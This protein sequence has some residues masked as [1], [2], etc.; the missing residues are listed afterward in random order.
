[1]VIIKP[2]RDSKKKST[3]PH[4]YRPIMRNIAPTRMP[5]MDV[6]AESIPRRIY[7]TMAPT[8]RGI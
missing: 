3:F 5:N 6:E 7:P 2:F 8:L 4:F 1:M